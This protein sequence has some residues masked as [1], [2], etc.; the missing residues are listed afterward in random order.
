MHREIGHL[1]QIVL[2][3]IAGG[4]F[5]YGSGF[6]FCDLKNYLGRKYTL[7]NCLTGVYIKMH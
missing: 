6:G 5:N 2:D 4:V 3:G 7:A 1:T